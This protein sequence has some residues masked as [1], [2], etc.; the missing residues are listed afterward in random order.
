MLTNQGALENS[1]RQDLWDIELQLTNRLAGHAWITTL[2]GW[3]QGE[4]S[5]V[6]R[7]ETGM[8]SQSPRFESLKGRALGR[9]PKQERKNLLGGRFVSS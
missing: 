8:D 5:Q 9:G 2:G 1:R 7:C 6:L 4:M 3:G